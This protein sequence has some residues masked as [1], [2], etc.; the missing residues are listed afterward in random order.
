MNT[1]FADMYAHDRHAR[2]I[3]D[4]A[5]ARRVREARRVNRK[6]RAR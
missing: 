6:H 5:N 1:Y 4:A 3:T 2:M